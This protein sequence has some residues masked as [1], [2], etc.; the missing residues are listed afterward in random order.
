MRSSSCQR[1]ETDAG[2]VTAATSMPVGVWVTD[3]LQHVAEPDQHRPDHERVDHDVA[4]E[5]VVVGATVH[6]RPEKAVL[7]VGCCT[8]LSAS[9]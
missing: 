9:S 3:V 7:H 6:P 8:K 4:E 5:E 1:I 2:S